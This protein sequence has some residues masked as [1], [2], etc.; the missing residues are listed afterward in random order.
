MKKIIFLSL[1]F[2]TN[3]ILAQ[4]SYDN[5]NHLSF[6]CDTLINKME[7]DDAIKEIEKQADIYS[8]NKKY[9]HALNC[10][11]F[12]SRSLH[13]FNQG[14]DLKKNAACLNFYIGQVYALKNNKDSAFKYLFIERKYNKCAAMH[15]LDIIVDFSF[16]KSDDRWIDLSKTE[17]L[18]QNDS[19]A[20]ELAIM[21]SKEQ[22]I[23]GKIEDFERTN[24]FN[25]YQYDSLYKEMRQIDSINNLKIKS[26]LQLTN[27]FP[28]KSIYGEK[29][30]LAAFTILQHVGWDDPHAS[31]KI[32]KDGYKKGDINPQMWAL[33]Y[34]RYQVVNEKKQLYGSQAKWDELNKKYIPC[35]IESPNQVNE[36]RKQM[37]MIN[38]EEYYD[39]L[40]KDVK[41]A[42]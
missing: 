17:I 4:P 27:G 39:L 26:I 10:Y 33:F 35:P 9:D 3:L 41:N 24:N 34:D 19:I 28:S 40:N 30:C 23:R 11:Y 20:N 12:I 7:F 5:L 16:L 18:N 13:N 14:K 6:W 37:G 15:Y 8:E 32:I 36:R 25:E 31:F 21:F 38:I 42:K 22:N 1:I 2:F 29:A